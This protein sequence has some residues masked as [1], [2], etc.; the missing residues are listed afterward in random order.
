MQK[1][2]TGLACLIGAAFLG[3]GVAIAVVMLVL[4]GV[5]ALIGR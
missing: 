5:A 1:I 2:G 4:F 3:D